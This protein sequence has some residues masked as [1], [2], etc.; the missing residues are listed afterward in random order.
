MITDGSYNSTLGL[1]LINAALRIA[2]D[3]KSWNTWFELDPSGVGVTWQGRPAWDFANMKSMIGLRYELITELPEPEKNLYPDMLALM[4]G[5]ADISIDYWGVNY[6]RNKLIDF[7]YPTQRRNI[8][9]VSGHSR[10]FVHADLVM[11][12]FDI[13]SYACLFSALAAMTFVMWLIS[14]NERRDQS[15]HK[16]LLLM[17]GNA[18]NQSINAPNV[19]KSFLGRSIMSLFSFYNY[20]ICLMY[21]SIV[22]S[23]LVSGSKPPQINS[24]EDLNKTENLHVR[25]IL[26]EKSFIREFLES[27][28]MLQGLH[29]RIDYAHITDD[30][31]KTIKRLLQG[32][33]VFITQGGDA[34]G[35]HVDV[36]EENRKAK[37]T[38]ANLDDF[39]KSRLDSLFKIGFN[40]SCNFQGSSFFNFRWSPYYAKRFSSC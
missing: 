20:I 25:I 33:H 3:C 16:C 5:V 17:V 1:G 2:V 19:S 4:K 37:T 6:K 27:A 21:G 14:K 7:S 22:I 31:N 30:R 24:L 11:G 9:I 13:F 18:V 36:C 28:N 38:L 26:K 10:E 34:Q 12:V 23:I 8:H 29:H 40:T 32:S 35:F 39:R 15:P